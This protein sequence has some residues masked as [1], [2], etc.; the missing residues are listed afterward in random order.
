M[1]T[2]KISLSNFQI[3]QSELKVL[4]FKLENQIFFS[5]SVTDYNN[6]NILKDF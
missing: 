4:L 2:F 6:S 5:A 1:K 3:Y